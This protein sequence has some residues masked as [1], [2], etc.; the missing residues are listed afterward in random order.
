MLERESEDPPTKKHKP[1]SG[2][3]WQE[4]DMF[5]MCVWS[6]VYML[7]LLCGQKTLEE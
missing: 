4:R 1:D 3:W 2:N 6:I 7:S 5:D